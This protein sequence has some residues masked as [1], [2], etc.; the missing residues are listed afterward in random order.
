M[1]SGSGVA[2]YRALNKA[3][4][5]AVELA[6]EAILRGGILIGCTITGERVCPALPQNE[7][8]LQNLKRT[9]LPQFWQTPIEF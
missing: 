6:R 5:L 4:T 1:A 9:V 8:E 2:M 7:L 3:S